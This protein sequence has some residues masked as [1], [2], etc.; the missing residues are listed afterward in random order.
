[1]RMLAEEHIT[2]NGMK[3]ILRDIRMTLGDTLYGDLLDLTAFPRVDESRINMFCQKMLI[4]SSSKNT[5]DSSYDMS[6]LD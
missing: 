1:M 6:S 2:K 3:A 4:D 5:E